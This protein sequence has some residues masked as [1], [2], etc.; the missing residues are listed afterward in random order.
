MNAT[1][2]PDSTPLA[3]MTAGQLRDLINE[4][5]SRHAEMM[6]QQERQHAETLLA[7][8]RSPRYITGLQAMA[9]HLG[10][11][12]KTFQRNRRRGLFDGVVH[13]MGRQFR[14]LDTELDAAFDRHNN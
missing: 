2:I 14:A 12:L 3:M 6:R 10:M 4:E 7:E 9:D 11:S 5:W 13:Q 8:K 1:M